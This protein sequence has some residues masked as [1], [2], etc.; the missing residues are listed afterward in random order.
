MICRRIF[1]RYRVFVWPSILCYDRNGVMLNIVFNILCHCCFLGK[2]RVLSL[3]YSLV[4]NFSSDE[5]Q[6][7]DLDQGYVINLHTIMQHHSLL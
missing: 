5:Y 6:G 7:T 3:M 4:V 2:N 1:A